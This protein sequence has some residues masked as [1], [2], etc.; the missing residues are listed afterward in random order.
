MN[1]R[2]PESK[3]KA[4]NKALDKKALKNTRGGSSSQTSGK[5]ATH[6]IIITKTVDKTSVNLLL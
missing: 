4:V 3:P 1:A 6:D 5:V 2:K